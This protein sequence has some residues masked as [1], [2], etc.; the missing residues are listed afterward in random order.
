MQSLRSFVQDEKK[1]I[2][3]F[4]VVLLVCAT[5]MGGLVA[6]FDGTIQAVLLTAP[7]AAGSMILVF[8]KPKVGLAILLFLAA[9]VL[10]VNQAVDL[11][12]LVGGFEL[13][14]IFLFVLWGVVLLRYRAIRFSKLAVL[15]IVT[16][17]LL[18]LIGAGLSAVWAWVRFS[19]DPF[20]ILR[21]L[22]AV[23]SYS[24]F[25]A[26]AIIVQNKNTIES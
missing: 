17:L 10:F 3:L 2:W 24:T 12:V 20:F 7:L 15:P 18:F 22:R 26:V 14:D 21:E 4:R 8:F 25:F 16:P 13:R 5:L 19:V 23:A 1:K 6:N 11:R 9:D